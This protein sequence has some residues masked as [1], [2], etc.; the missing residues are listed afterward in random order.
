MGGYLSVGTWSDQVN[1][2]DFSQSGKKSAPLLL[3]AKIRPKL[4][5][6]FGIFVFPSQNDRWD[7]EFWLLPVS[8]LLDYTKTNVLFELLTATYELTWPI[9]IT[10]TPSSIAILENPISLN[11]KHFWNGGL[12]WR[13]GFVLDSIC[14]SGVLFLC[15]KKLIRSNLHWFSFCFCMWK[16][17]RLR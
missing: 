2:G 4:N 5:L 17:S 16:L 11:F 9:F 13:S 14:P 7:A 15:V 1:F 12:C 8:V 3:H 10:K 6:E